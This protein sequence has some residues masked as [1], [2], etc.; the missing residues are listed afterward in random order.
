MATR[1]APIM[2]E[3]FY[4]R[5]SSLTT[6]GKWLFY[7]FFERLGR[8]ELRHAHRG[9]L[10]GGTS[11]RVAG[12]ASRS[13]FGLETAEPRDGDLA[14]LLELA[15]N[16]FDHGLDCALCFGLG[17]SKDAVHLLRDILLVHDFATLTVKKPFKPC[18]G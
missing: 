12:G 17:G 2:S 6:S 11:A 4:E 18:A 5:G 7:C 3:L 8:L 1:K 13:H 14:S 15:N 9:N 16:A 10:Y